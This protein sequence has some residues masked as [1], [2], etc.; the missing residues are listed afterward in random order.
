MAGVREVEMTGAAQRAA[1]NE[2][3]SL[4][5]MG[6]TDDEIRHLVE[7]PEVPRAALLR[8]CKR[9]PEEGRSIKAAIDFRDFLMEVLS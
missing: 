1:L 5:E 3:R 8:F 7:V 9:H 2:L 6:M 4:R